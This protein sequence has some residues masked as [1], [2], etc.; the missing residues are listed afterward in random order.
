[1]AA[2]IR[3]VLGPIVW[4]AHFAFVYGAHTALCAVGPP[5]T[6]EVSVAI[7]VGIATCA[8]LLTLLLAGMAPGTAVPFRRNVGFLLTVLSAIA[9]AWLGITA[10]IV[11]VCTSP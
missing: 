5:G 2:L 10:I 9:I 6:A 4:A 8:A 7:A 11:P 3:L 1:M